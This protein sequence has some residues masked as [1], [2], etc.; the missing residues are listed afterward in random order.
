M[1]ATNYFMHIRGKGTCLNGSKDEG[2]YPQ[3]A[4]EPKIAE[5][6]SALTFGGQNMS[7]PYFFLFGEKNI[8]PKFFFFFQYFGIL[9]NS[10]NCMQIVRIQ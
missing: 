3:V 1:L 9:V 8:I 10:A 4:G 2:V 5:F 6:G 7:N